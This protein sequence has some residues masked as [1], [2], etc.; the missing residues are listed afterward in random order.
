VKRI[1][2]R[3]REKENDEIKNNLEVNEEKTPSR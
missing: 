1:G 2:K 3:E